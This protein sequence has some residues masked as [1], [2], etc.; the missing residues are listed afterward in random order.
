MGVVRLNL[1][2][3]VAE[4][5]ERIR[6]AAQRA[7]RQ[8]EEIILVG[9]TKGVSP[10]VI[11]QAFDAGIKIAGENRAQEL[12]AKIPQVTRPVE[13]H[14]IGALQT[15]KVRQILNKVALIHSLDRFSLAEEIARVARR[16]GIAARALVQVNVSR[17]TTKRG[18]EVKEV[19]PFLAEVSKYEGLQ[20]EGLMT[21]APLG[22]ESEA[23]RVFGQLRRLAEEVEKEGFPRV[24]MRY[25]SMGMT[26][27]FEVAIE[28]GSNMVRI[29]RGLFGPR[30]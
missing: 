19:I 3:R 16:Q 17:E 26:D 15:N 22:K 1:R 30:G 9:V 7:G 12:L 27:D 21:I 6:Q 23:R 25:L 24:Q 2:E 4:V 14:F 28:E 10:E 13:W 18:L 29:G 20:V 11:N 8:P 5:Q